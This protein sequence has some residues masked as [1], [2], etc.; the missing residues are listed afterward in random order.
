MAFASALKYGRF[1][2]IEHTVF[3]LPLLVSGAL[4]ARDE[5]TLRVLLLI[6]VAGTGARTAAL[7][8]NRL[9][10]RKIDRDNPRTRGRELP[11]GIMSVAEAW[12]VTGLGVVVFLLAA[13]AISPLCLWLSPIPLAL[14]ILY[15]LL[16]RLTM[17]AHLG[18]GAALA[19]GP[20]G[21]W[22]AVK[23]EFTD[24]EN[25]LLLCFFTFF[26]VSGFDIIYATLDIDFDRS[27]G[28]HSLPA[29]LGREAALRVSLGLHLLAFGLLVTLYV[30][31][32]EGVVS[33]LLLA[34]VGALLLVEHQKA[35]DVDLAFFKVNAIVGFVVLGLVV[36][37]TQM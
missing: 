29:R 2:K 6:L 32:L 17:W 26:W 3:S 20:L 19:M 35:G 7:G 28:L 5:L 25:A 13:L 10:D 8:F 30:R 23:L 9:L 14:F 34:L 24:F 33:L 37:G 15:P 16:K 12:L 31:A 18:V 36:A 1:V 11:S 21:A 4:L 22:F 27:Y